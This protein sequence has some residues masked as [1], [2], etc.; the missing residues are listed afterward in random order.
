MPER[1][2]TLPRILAHRGLHVS[3]PENTLSAFAAAAAAGARWIELDVML[4][5]DHVPIIFHD[6]ALERVTN[7]CGLVAKQSLL[8]LQQLQVCHQ[9]AIDVIPSLVQL[10]D[11]IALTDLSFN[12]EI[13]SNSLGDA[14]TCQ[15]ILAVLKTHS[16]VP[17]LLKE[18]RLFVSSFSRVV[19]EFF[20]Q[21]A[22]QIPRA[23]LLDGMQPDAFQ[24]ARAQGCVAVNFWAQMPDAEQFLTEA[25]AVGMPTLCFTVDEVME[26]NHWFTKG[27]TGVFSNNAACYALSQQREDV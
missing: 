20:A 19:V 23:Y 24:F 27:V 16:A 1:I 7:G 14:L 18:Q 26:A 12:L 6:D 25:L 10:L 3:A 5:S 9:S 11:Y 4:S 8:A 22:P 2:F 21:Q 15:H 13:K 17:C